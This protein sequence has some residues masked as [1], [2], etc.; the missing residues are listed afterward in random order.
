[1]P[2]AFYSNRNSALVFSAQSGFPAGKNTARV[3]YKPT[4]VIQVFPVNL[5]F[6]VGAVQANFPSPLEPSSAPVKRARWSTV[7]SPGGTS[8]I[9]AGASCTRVFSHYKLLLKLYI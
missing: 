4:Q 7:S 8:P 2:G 3:V 1:M 5:F 6:F 9:L